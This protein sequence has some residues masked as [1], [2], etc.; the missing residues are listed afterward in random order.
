[1]Q[2]TGN[3]GNFVHV[4]TPTGTKL[5]RYDSIRAFLNNWSNIEHV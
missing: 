1:M 5:I 4:E 3:P 2:L